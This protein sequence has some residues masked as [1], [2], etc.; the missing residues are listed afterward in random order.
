MPL[1]KADTSGGFDPVISTGADVT[2]P[3]L[4]ALR[5]D[6][7]LEKGT[8]SPAIH[9]LLLNMA[10]VKNV[11]SSLRLEDKEIDLERARLAVQG[12]HTFDP[13]ER[14]V[15]RFAK[16]YAWIDRT[17]TG[18]LPDLSLDLMLD[19]HAELLQ[20]DEDI[21][22]DHLG[23]LK[24]EQNS[25]MDRTSGR[26]RFY[27]TPPERTEAELEALLAWYNRVSGQSLP[28]AVA[29]IFFAE[30]QAIHPFVDGN[31]RLG[32][33]LNVLLLKKLGHE[34]VAL[35]P[36]DG[37]FFATQDKYYEKIASTNDG[38]TWFVWT[39]YFAKQLQRAYEIAVRRADLRPL[40]DE[41]SSDVTRDVLEWVL[42][43]AGRQFKRGDY[44]NP[45]GYSLSSITTAL[46]NLVEQ[47]ILEP[48]GEKRGRTY[49][50]S[51]EFLETVYA[52][53]PDEL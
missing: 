47:G 20:D 3:C 6:G 53:L 46:G 39:R 7:M 34:N 17:P 5:H 12:G 48:E 8:L 24:E 43:G 44:P 35:V 1:E 10:R 33:I 38:E 45:D 42:Q 2:R 29:A 30:L 51:T 49:R 14:Q 31:G 28:G 52:G 41:Q 23:T 4:H 26:V 18:D 19:W 22:P 36:L 15:L 13:N 16:K 37:R 11:V 32:R 21:D 25:I 40:L 27:P 9:R 50:L